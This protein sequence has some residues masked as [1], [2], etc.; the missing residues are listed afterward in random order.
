[1][2]C[3][4]QVIWYFM[5]C[6]SFLKIEISGSNHFASNFVLS[7]PMFISVEHIFETFATD[8]TYGFLICHVFKSEVSS[9]IA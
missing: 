1:M 2:Q 7:G 5:E 9:C 6:L 3:I 8:V 4:W